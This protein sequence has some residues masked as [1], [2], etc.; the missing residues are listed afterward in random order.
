MDDFRRLFFPAALVAMLAGCGLMIR[1]PRPAGDLLQPATASDESVSLE[2]YFVRLPADGDDVAKKLWPLVDEQE[3]PSDLR[4]DLAKNG[5]RAGVVGPQMPDVLAELLRLTDEAPAADEPPK[6][7][8]LDE[9]PPVRK[10]LL[11][12][13][14]G[15]RGEIIAAPTVAEMPLLVASDGALTGKTFRDAQAILAA[16][17]RSAGGEI[18]LSLLPEVHHGQARQQWAGQ[19]GI[20]RLEMSRPKE[21]FANLGLHPHLGAGQ[22]LVVGCVPDASGSLGHQFFTEGASGGRIHKLLVVRVAQIP[23]VPA[24]TAE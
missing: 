1:A 23:P 7:V 19:D 13:R 20:M 3:L 2:I 18:E 4:L 6:G 24:L 10:R 11:Q 12:L 8:A 15:H 17:V 14:F 21:V 5:L 9:E 16:D 22:M